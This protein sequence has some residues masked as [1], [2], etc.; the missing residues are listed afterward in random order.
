MSIQARGISC[1]TNVSLIEVG[2]SCNSAPGLPHV[3]V[4][5]PLRLEDNNGPSTS[6]KVLPCQYG[7][8]F[9]DLQVLQ[10][11]FGYDLDRVLAAIEVLEEVDN[12][13]VTRGSVW[14]L[15]L[16]AGKQEPMQM[17]EILL[18]D[19]GSRK[20]QWHSMHC[21]WIDIESQRL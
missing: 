18:G 4:I 15:F 13:P 12:L 9:L 1:L 19:R 17:T 3:F 2:T 6:M 5:P 16:L 14:A 20:L 10:I 21:P 11:C 7:L 8:R